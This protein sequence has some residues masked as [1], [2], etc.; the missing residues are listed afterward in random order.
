MERMRNLLSTRDLDSEFVQQLFNRA[1]KLKRM[2]GILSSHD[3]VLDGETVVNLFWEVSTRTRISF[4]LAASHL[5]AR[6]VTIFPQL[7]SVA[8]GEGLYDT[9]VNLRA[10]GCR[11][12]VIRHPASGEVAKLAERASKGVHIVNAGDGTNEHPSQALLDV[13]TMR[14]YKKSMKGLEVA[15]LGDILRSRVARSNL[16]LLS[17]LGAKCRLSGPPE[18]LPDRLESDAAVL[19]KTVDEAIEGADIVMMLRVQREREGVKLTI[20]DAEYHKKYGLTPERFKR[21]KEDALIMHPGPI[22]RGV[23]IDADL[24][25]GPQSLILKQA[26]NGLF[27]RMAIFEALRGELG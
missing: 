2:R 17:R 23:E 21:A 15:I 24:A 11:F 7:S 14:E 9:L 6:I 3:A 16:F 26:E 20:S 5:G 19:T 13:F 12:F 4:E 22:Q 27:M 25:D 1:A 10:L 8:K 18:L